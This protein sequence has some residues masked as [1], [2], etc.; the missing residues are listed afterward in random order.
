MNI[1]T[2]RPHHS[3]RKIAGSPGLMHP[4]RY[5]MLLKQKSGSQHRVALNPFMS[6]YK[7]R[8]AKTGNIS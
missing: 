4:A 1:V 2:R 3:R 8:T 7:T 5:F 6:K